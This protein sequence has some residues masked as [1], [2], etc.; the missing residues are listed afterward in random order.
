[1]GMDQSLHEF[2][3]LQVRLRESG[4]AMPKRLRQVAEFVLS[5]AED[6]AFA[7]AAEVAEA[8]HVQPSTLV[9]FAKTIGFSGFSDLQAV[10]RTRLRH[11]FPD[12]R[13]RLATLRGAGGPITMFDGFARAAEVSLT[14]ARTSLNPVALE[15]AVALLAK[16]D[17]VYLLGARRVYP[18]AA[19]LF[20]A[21]S[22]L[23]VRAVLIDNSGGMAPEQ[24]NS[25]RSGDA[26]MV[27]SYAPYAAV[28]LET[29]R[30]AKERS[31]P[32]VAIT[33]SPFSPLAPLADVW[34]EIAE[35]DFGAFRSL[36][37]TH[38]LAM[39][40]AVATAEARA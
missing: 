29:A 23:D 5:H 24:V 34:L 38:A 33:D 13:Q 2:E 35:A 27:V 37:A 25:A 12:Y 1:M 18:M 3:A 6:F 15:N 7:T 8:A 28:T 10:Y 31:V 32:V 19:A 20:Y 11:G 21:F 40:L 26:L 4:P 14:R 16:S 36:A 17:T 39:T 9:R 30:L 22:K